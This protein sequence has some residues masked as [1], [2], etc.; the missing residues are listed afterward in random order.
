MSTKKTKTKKM[1][2]ITQIRSQIGS[3]ARQKKVLAGLGLGRIGR[4][5][6]RPNDP[7]ILGM[8]AKVG[9]LVT[10]EEVEA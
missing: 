9:H 6:I 5:V 2:K 8:V 10:V 4:S 1:V 7:C 3:Q